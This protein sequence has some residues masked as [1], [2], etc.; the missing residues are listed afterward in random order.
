LVQLQFGDDH[1]SHSYNYM[2]MLN[3][4]MILSDFTFSVQHNGNPY[5]A[6]ILCNLHVYPTD[7]MQDLQQCLNKF[8]T[9]GQRP[10]YN[11]ACNSLG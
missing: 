1:N 10:D 4:I 6:K 8:R 3:E 11:I 2:Y 7:Q 9:G 5:R